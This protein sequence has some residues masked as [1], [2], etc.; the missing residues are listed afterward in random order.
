MTGNWKAKGDLPQVIG[1]V[2]KF[3]LQASEAEY[4]EMKQLAR[5]NLGTMKGELKES[6]NQPRTITES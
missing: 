2:E 3:I 4:S 6:E 5:A 1:D